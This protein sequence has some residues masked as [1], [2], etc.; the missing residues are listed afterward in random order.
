MADVDAEIASDFAKRKMNVG[1]VVSDL[2]RIHVAA[3]SLAIPSLKIS[4]L[5]K[6]RRPLFVV[7]NVGTAVGHTPVL[8]SWCSIFRLGQRTKLVRR[9][10][11]SP[12]GT[13]C[14]KGTGI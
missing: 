6:L 11:E 5:G 2:P 8:A 7:H 3:G 9:A 4:D 14:V 1:I 13:A 12:V 10:A